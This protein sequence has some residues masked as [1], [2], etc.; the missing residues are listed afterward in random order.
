MKISK[1]KLY[2]KYK[3]GYDRGYISGQALVWRGIAIVLFIAFIIYASYYFGKKIYAPN[4]PILAIENVTK[5]CHNESEIIGYAFGN[6]S[7]KVFNWT[8]CYDHAWSENHYNSWQSY[9]CSCVP[10]NALAVELCKNNT[11]CRFKEDISGHYLWTIEK[12]PCNQTIE[13]KTA[14]TQIK[15]VCN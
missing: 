11:L 14:I 7:I 10:D 9:E 5:S 6:N 1:Q 3:E 15:E 4:T 2:E 8:Y 12:K 13:N